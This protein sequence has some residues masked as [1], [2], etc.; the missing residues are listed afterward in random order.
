MRTYSN[1]SPPEAVR[2]VAVLHTPTPG[3][4]DRCV[5]SKEGNLYVRAC[6][7]SSQTRKRPRDA[8]VRLGHLTRPPFSLHLP[9]LPP[10]LPRPPRCC[11]TIETY[12]NT[13][14][15]PSF[16]VSMTYGP[17]TLRRSTPQ[18]PA[19]SK[20]AVTPRHTRRAR[21]LASRALPRNHTLVGYASYCT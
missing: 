21:H 13:S 3:S 1:C 10:T 7:A 14:M 20:L 2:G 6:A 16:C 18:V 15:F 11:Y 19:A 4:C 17:P 5:R 9:A 8:S 12:L